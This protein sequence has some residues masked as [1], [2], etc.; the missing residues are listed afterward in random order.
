MK[1]KETATRLKDFN[2]ETDLQFGLILWGGGKNTF[3]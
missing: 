2:G 1:M 3:F